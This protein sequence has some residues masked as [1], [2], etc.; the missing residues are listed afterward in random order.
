MADYNTFMVYDC[1][2]R[3]T[4]LITS[5]AR[6]AKNM[7][8]T[9]FKIE[10]WNSNNLIET[11]YTKQIINLDRYISLEKEYIKRKQLKAKSRNDKRR[12][13]YGL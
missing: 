5:S 3:K 13:K 7:L 11:I 9:G 8:H 10:V 6:K 12:K 1:K 4:I 2:K